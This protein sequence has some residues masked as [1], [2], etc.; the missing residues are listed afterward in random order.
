M[1]LTL[2]G[3]DIKSDQNNKSEIVKTL[4][5]CLR[6][7]DKYTHG[8]SLRVAYYCT[9]IGASLDLKPE[10]KIELELAGLLHDLGKI[11]IP[12][13]ILLKPARLDD[14]E[15]K[16]MQMHPVKTSI[17]LKSLTELDE[18]ANIA[19]HHHERYDGNGYPNGLVAENIP[20]F[21]RAI[22]IADTFDAMTSTRPYRKGLPY[23][24]A[25]AE[26]NKFAGSQFDPFLV[27]RFINILEKN[28]EEK[29]ENFALSLLPGEFKKAA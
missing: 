10:E 6:Q 17:I 14:E 4:L 24:M 15:F 5:A 7:K 22:L 13:N 12:D 8:H 9:L 2:S 28:N 21:S 1:F 23:E 11:G 3:V 26:L 19:K 18:V 16:V 29:Q 25:F 20:L 27:K